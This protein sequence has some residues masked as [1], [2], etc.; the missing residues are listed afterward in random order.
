VVTRK[1]PG[2]DFLTIQAAI[3]AINTTKKSKSFYMYSCTDKSR[4]A[5]PDISAGLLFQA[6]YLSTGYVT[7]GGL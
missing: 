6:S 7:Y 2:E 4:V 3:D 1:N 5:E